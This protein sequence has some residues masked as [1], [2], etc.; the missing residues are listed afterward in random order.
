MSNPGPDDV[1]QLN[2]PAFQDWLSNL[3]AHPTEGQDHDRYARAHTAAQQ[4][5]STGWR[6]TENSCAVSAVEGRAESVALIERALWCTGDGWWF[7]GDLAL[8]L[9]RTRASGAGAGDQAV[10]KEKQALQGTWIVARRKDEK[11]VFSRRQ[12]HSKPPGGKVA[13]PWTPTGN[14]SCCTP[15]ARPS[16]TADRR[17]NGDDFS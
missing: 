17:V 7:G 11:L 10:K 4:K 6:W 13:S 8:G 3:P 1:N 14:R 2:D 9:L 15:R 16:Q 12:I 5:T